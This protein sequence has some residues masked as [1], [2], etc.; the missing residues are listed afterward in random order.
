[1]NLVEEVPHE[2][3]PSWQIIGCFITFHLSELV[4]LG[5]HIWHRKITEKDNHSRTI[6]TAT[7]ILHFGVI[8]LCCVE[9]AATWWAHSWIFDHLLRKLRE[10]RAICFEASEE[11]IRTE[12]VG[13]NGEG[14]PN[15]DNNAAT[16]SG[17]GVI[18]KKTAVAEGGGADNASILPHL[19]ISPDS[20][21]TE[22]VKLMREHLHRK[23]AMLNFE[24]QAIRRNGDTVADSSNSNHS[25]S[26][27]SDLGWTVLTSFGDEAAVFTKMDGSHD[28]DE[29]AEEC[30]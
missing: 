7:Y 8:A 22:D 11:L 19:H 27:N 21:F 26:P 1:V 4:L 15:E 16:I 6:T 25:T 14:N 23:Q 2:T 13:Y 5:M 10:L 17:G 28:D 12:Q 30:N 24:P 20:P 3:N 29:F 18:D 9:L